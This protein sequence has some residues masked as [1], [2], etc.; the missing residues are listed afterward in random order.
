MLSSSRGQLKTLV[1]LTMAVLLFCRSAKMPP[2]LSRFVA[3]RVRAAPD[4]KRA[5]AEIRHH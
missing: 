1:F 3:S 2:G 5:A 4:G